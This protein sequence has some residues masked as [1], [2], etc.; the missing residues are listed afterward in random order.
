VL[1]VS[2]IAAIETEPRASRGVKGC[3]AVSAPACHIVWM[4][5]R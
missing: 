5:G 1:A 4:A 2:Y 3:F